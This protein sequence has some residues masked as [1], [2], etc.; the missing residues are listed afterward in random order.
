MQIVI[1]ISKEFMDDFKEDKFENCFIREFGD[2]IKNAKTS[3]WITRA[4]RSGNYG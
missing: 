4:A 1:D 2:K 3:D